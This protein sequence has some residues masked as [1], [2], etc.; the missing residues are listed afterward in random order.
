LASQ[1]TQSVLKQLG[2]LVPSSSDSGGEHS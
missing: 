1:V 2:S